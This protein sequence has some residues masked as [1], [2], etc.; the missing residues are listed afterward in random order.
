MMTN[1]MA[2][3]M[4]NIRRARRG[5]TV[6]L[7]LTVLFELSTIPCVS[8]SVASHRISFLSV[9]GSVYSF[10]VTDSGR[11]G[12]YLPVSFEDGT[13]GSFEGLHVPLGE[14]IAAI[15]AI[16]SHTVAIS[17]AGTVYHISD[18]SPAIQRFAGYGIER[19]VSIVENAVVF[20]ANAGEPA[21][22][23]VSAFFRL[24]Y[25]IANA[26]K[27]IAKPN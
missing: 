24:A 18:T 27:L 23:P 6:E 1:S 12:S 10:Q 19:V 16:N 2:F 4:K 8:S 21:C 13:I 15:T 11:K 20:S 22:R 14:P 26:N 17:E 7:K 25:L 9:D 3:L 5:E